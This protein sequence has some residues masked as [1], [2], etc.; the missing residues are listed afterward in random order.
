MFSQNLHNPSPVIYFFSVLY[1]NQIGNWDKIFALLNSSFPELELS[2]NSF[3]PSH[4][5]LL[6]YYAKQM[7]GDVGE[8]SRIFCHSTKPMSREELVITKTKAMTLENSFSSPYRL[9]NIDPG[10]VA[11]EHL[12]LSSHKPFA[13]RIY[14]R[15]G[16]YIELEYLFQNQ[17]WVTLPWTYPDYKDDEKKRFF[18]TVRR[19]TL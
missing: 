14:L 7:G 4:N 12:V 11:Q 15:N 2:T 1:H 3:S 9:L 16:I 5:P 19:L 8:L 13:H 10:Y 18:L 6:D 17:Q